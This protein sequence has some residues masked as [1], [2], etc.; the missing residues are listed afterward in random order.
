MRSVRQRAHVTALA[1][2][3]AIAAQPAA[4]EPLEEGARLHKVVFGGDE[5]TEKNLIF[6]YVAGISYR[7]DEGDMRICTAGIIGERLLLTAGHCVPKDHRSI[8]VFFSVDLE[9]RDRIPASRRRKVVDIAVHEQYAEAAKDKTR[10]NPYDIAILLT[11]TPMP[12]YTRHL[13][14]PNVNFPISQISRAYVAGYGRRD[15]DKSTGQGNG[16]ERLRSAIVPRQELNNDIFLMTDQ[17]KGTG[18]CIGDSGGPMM[19]QNAIGMIA[20]G[21]LSTVFN[22]DHRNQCLG[23]ATYISVAHYRAW[24]HEQSF[25]MLARP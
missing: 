6:Q 23:T 13:Q 7:A 12:A 1:L 15:H 19:V 11:D 24:I 14:L 16:E 10:A 5:M 2:A 25:H 9:R 4:P 18:T 20:M 3:M 21:V 17:T 22:G 8:E